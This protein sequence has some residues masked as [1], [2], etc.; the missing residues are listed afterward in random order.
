MCWGSIAQKS[1]GQIMLRHNYIY[2][3]LGWDI[4]HK[5]CWDTITFTLHYVG[6]GHISEMMLGHN[7]RSDTISILNFRTELLRGF[8][9]HFVFLIQQIIHKT[10]TYILDGCTTMDWVYQGGAGYTA[11]MFTSKQHGPIKILDF[12]IFAEY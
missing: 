12:V 1:I 9:N 6:M 7:Y 11:D 5:L 4:S 3:M 10:P 8:N 2:I